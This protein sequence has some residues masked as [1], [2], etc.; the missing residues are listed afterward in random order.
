MSKFLDSLSI[1]QGPH[2]LVYLPLGLCAFHSSSSNSS[3][4]NRLFGF[5]GGVG[6][7]DF[8]GVLALGLERLGLSSAHASSVSLKFSVV[9]NRAKIAAFL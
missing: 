1:S 7:G 5:L 4:L 2:D 8:G 3:F 9:R 6:L